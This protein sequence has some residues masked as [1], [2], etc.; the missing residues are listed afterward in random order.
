MIE[1]EAECSLCG[2]HLSV[3]VDSI[4]CKNNTVVLCVETCSSC[5]ADAHEEG[6]DKG[7]AVG[8]EDTEKL[9]ELD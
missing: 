6:Y 4:G 8:C 3:Q 7:Y 2:E 5:V 9:Q 1:I